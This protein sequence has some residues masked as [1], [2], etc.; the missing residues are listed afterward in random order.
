MQNSI[1]GVV[2]S[3]G[4]GVKFMSWSS[5]IPPSWKMKTSMPKVAVTLRMF[6]TTAFSGMTTE[7]TCTKRIRHVARKM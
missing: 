5:P 6:I 3:I 7:R 1:T 2:G 4:S